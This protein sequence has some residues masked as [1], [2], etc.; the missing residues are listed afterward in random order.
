[1]RGPIGRGKATA[2]VGDEL[3]AR[4]TLTFAVETMIGSANG[5]RIGIT[6]LGVHVPDRVVTN[7]ELA[8]LRRHLRRVDRRAYRDPRAPDRR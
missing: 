8:Q 2:H 3:A 6:G 7:D 5:V 1:M 4:G